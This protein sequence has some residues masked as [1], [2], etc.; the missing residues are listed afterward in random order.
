MADDRQDRIELIRKLDFFSSLNSRVVKRIG[1]FAISREYSKG[2]YVIKRGQVGLGLF[3]IIE[4]NVRVEIETE[5]GKVVIHE[6]GGGDIF[7]EMS[8]VDNKPRSADIVCSER[9]KCL[10]VTRDSLGKLSNRHPE[11]YLQIARVLAERLRTLNERVARR[12]GTSESVQRDGSEEADTGGVMARPPK[13]QF[14]ELLVSAFGQFH[15]LKALSRY[16]V[17]LVGCPLRVAVSPSCGRTLQDEIAEVKVAIFPTRRD[18]TLTLRA[19]EEGSFSA[20]VLQPGGGPATHFE[21]RLKSGQDLEIVVPSNGR[22]VPSLE[23]GG[24][25]KENQ[26]PGDGAPEEA[27]EKRSRVESLG[28]T[29]VDSLFQERDLD[30]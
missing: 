3:A 19:F 2:D 4:G 7:G 8:L 27:D 28:E 15:S 18:R 5:H 20:T 17:A 1:D 16:S 13:R 30:R 22:G 26:P 25:V 29:L 10:L 9:T 23:P 21:G 12:R 11:I 6:L 14:E 24:R